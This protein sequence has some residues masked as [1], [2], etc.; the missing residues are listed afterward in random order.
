MRINQE[1]TERVRYVEKFE[2][3][4]SGKSTRLRSDEYPFSRAANRQMPVSKWLKTRF[5]PTYPTFHA[6][7]IYPDGST[8]RPDIP[9]GVIR[10]AYQAYTNLYGQSM[11]FKFYGSSESSIIKLKL[12]LDKAG[13]NAKFADSSFLFLWQ[14]FTLEGE[15]SHIHLPIA[16]RR[17]IPDMMSSFNNSQEISFKYEFSSDNCHLFEA[18]SNYY[19]WGIEQFT[20]LKRITGW[21]KF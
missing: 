9:I 8:V 5:Q 7:V 17:A 3:I 13:I 12:A 21:N 15:I 16:Y 6:S 18:D 19:F 20:S 1:I 11:W 14:R 4:V 2:I 10:D